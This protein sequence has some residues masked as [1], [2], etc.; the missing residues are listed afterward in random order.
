VTTISQGIDTYVVAGDD[1]PK[2]VRLDVAY[3]DDGNTYLA[4]FPTGFDDF[5]TLALDT[6]TIY[7]AEAWPAGVSLSLKLIDED[8]QPGQVTDTTKP[9]TSGTAATTGVLGAKVAGDAIT[10]TITSQAQEWA[11][12]TRP[13]RGVAIT[14]LDAGA[15]VKMWSFNSDLP[16]VQEVTPRDTLPIPT[17]L[18]PAGGRAV[19]AARV[20][21]R[22]KDYAIDLAS[23]ELA[24]MW[25]EWSTSTS[26]A[27]P[28]ASDVQLTSTPDFDMNTTQR[29]TAADGHTTNG[30]A[31]VT[32]ATAA[33]TPY[34]VGTSI[35][36]TG[37][38]GGT[39]ILSY[40]SAT[41]V[42]M[43]ANATATA[44]TVVF[45]IGSGFGLSGTVSYWRTNLQSTDGSW[46]GWSDPESTRFVAVGSLTIDS[47]AA[48]PGNVSADP[49]PLLEYTYGGTEVQHQYTRASVADPAVALGDTGKTPSLTT[50]EGRVGY[51]VLDYGSY[52]D[53][54]RVWDSV[55]REDIPGYPSYAEATRT[56]SLTDDASVQSPTIDSVAQ[57]MQWSPFITVS[58]TLPH[59]AS[60]RVKA[61]GE[62]VS[63]LLDGADVLVS[64]DEGGRHY[65]WT[66]YE[67]TS[68]VLYDIRVQAVTDGRGSA[69]SEVASILV[70][71]GGIWLVDPEDG[72]L[73]FIAGQNDPG[74]TQPEDATTYHPSGG[75]DK[76]TYAR[77]VVTN[78]MGYRSDSLS[79]PLIDIFG[80]NAEQWHNH[81][82]SLRRRPGKEL[83]LA[84]PRESIPVVIGEP[85]SFSDLRPG[86]TRN[87]AFSWEQTRPA[88][89]AGTDSTDPQT[90]T[91]LIDFES[92]TAGANITSA[93][94]SGIVL[95]PVGT[96][97]ANVA[98]KM[99]GSTMG[100]KITST[101]G[102]AYLPVSVNPLANTIDVYS[103]GF[104]A[105]P[106]T[107]KNMIRWPQ[108]GSQVAAI[109]M[110]TS[111]AIQIQDAG[112]TRLV[113]T[114]ARIPI[115]T[116]F[117]L[118]GSQVWND[119]VSHIE[120]Q[121]YIGLNT[122]GSVPDGAIEWDVAAVSAP[123]PRV[124]IGSVSTAGYDWSIDD[125]RVS[126]NTASI[127][128]PLGDA[129]SS[130]VTY[131]RPGD[132]AIDGF[133]VVSRISGAATSVKVA[134][135]TTQGSDGFPSSPTFS[136]AASVDANGFAKHILTGLTANTNYYLAI[137]NTSNVII[138]GAGKAKTF[139]A[140]N[141]SWTMNIG[142]G[143]CQLGGGH[144]TGNAAWTDAQSYSPDLLVQQ[145][146]FGYWGGNLTP[147]S[148]LADHVGRYSTQTTSLG[149]MKTVLANVASL[150]QVSDHEV[151]SNGQYQDPD[152]TYDYV[153]GLPII[154]QNILAMRIACPVRAYAD[155][156]TTPR[157]RYRYLDLGHNGTSGAVNIRLFMLDFRTM[158][159]SDGF[160]TDGPSKTAFG[161]AQLAWLSA[162]LL[163]TGLNILAHEGM[164]YG[165][166]TTPNPTGSV[167]GLDK[168]TSYRWEQTNILLPMFSGKQIIWW[169][170]DRH[171]LGYLHKTQ[172]PL[173]GFT[174]CIAS[175]WEMHGLGLQPGE[176]YKD[177][178]GVTRVF[179]DT[180]DPDN[181]NRQYGRIT[182]ADNNAGTIT[183][184]WNGRDANTGANV[185]GP[186]I[187]TFTY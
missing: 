155:G 173:G 12:C 31:I 138:G 51:E 101:S 16:P 7:A 13:N 177:S 167:V 133:V 143:S 127:E 70:T 20:P 39:K 110:G 163:S 164:W 81:L 113:F 56:W 172:N 182:L 74:V 134:Y 66:W 89:L 130:T 135:S 87:A 153:G 103:S 98:A 105:L 28:T 21:L 141:T 67:S 45:T 148:T 82:M 97:Q 123:D 14:R 68:N 160:D 117:R 174:V 131:M 1:R 79:G 36:G 93:D 78:Q 181:P 54:V 57:L 112:G 84:F 60:F 65:A 104:T 186:F 145:G 48:P 170:G 9:A 17:G 43:T 91:T 100:C 47:P 71:A 119:G 184:T 136:S 111:G 34:D 42:T 149:A 10:F 128:S 55:D 64:E 23:I 151:C 158:D 115:N 62:N 165:D 152:L 5:D 24:A 50:G 106:G 49:D 37:I 52:I 179:G 171:I 40:T 41:Q 107:D 132:P 80:L 108:S 129:P 175:A 142:Q 53:T 86:Q 32:S 69:T 146:D 27:S 183:H 30:S 2:D 22:V 58:W 63:G 185:L 72:K 6:F 124:H 15:T 11:D 46:S 187:D 147:S 162:N 169:G 122:E 178:G 150:D 33:F 35:S 109:H 168:L 4:K 18:S 180:N 85:T 44:T 92:Y 102:G 161:A 3:L 26:F 166:V 159:K 144:S 139:P 76:Q 95:T 99:H 120:A 140:A 154:Q 38:P 19:S 88:A 29:V 61:N 176:I 156:A 116:P 114:A 25:V 96:V 75:S 90:V 126:N 157:G 125:V 137:A 73:V 83:I 8:W 94:P 59:N 77:R 121:V 118:I